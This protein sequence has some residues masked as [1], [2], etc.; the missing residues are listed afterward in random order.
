MID[1]YFVQCFEK[2][3]VT[4]DLTPLVCMSFHVKLVNHN[5]N[6][7]QLLCS[8]SHIFPGTVLGKLTQ[9]TSIIIANELWRDSMQTNDT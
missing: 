3:R 4:I 9:V 8:W 7:G 5:L 1:T 6:V 2:M